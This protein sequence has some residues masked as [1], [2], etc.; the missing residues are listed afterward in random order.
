MTTNAHKL[1]ASRL[2]LT[3]GDV[4]DLIGIAMIEAHDP[5]GL[6]VVDLGAG[7]GTTALA[8]LQIRLD[9][10]VWTVDTV[11][12]NLHWA[13]ANLKGFGEQLAGYTTVSHYGRETER[14]A[15]RWTP[16]QGAAA[17]FAEEWTRAKRP[18]ADVLL[19]DA[20]H[21]EKDV[22]DDVLAWLPNLHPEAVIWVHDYYRMPGGEEYP[23]VARAIARLVNDGYVWPLEAKAAG[24]GWLGMPGWRYSEVANGI[25]PA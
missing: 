20:G 18:L 3:A 14:P 8:I 15:P 10:H 13:E 19:H 24:I 1:A 4:D 12:A 22:Y 16:W 5:T 9:A 17:A 21:E 7:S 2:F 11:L 6:Y 25:R 23:G